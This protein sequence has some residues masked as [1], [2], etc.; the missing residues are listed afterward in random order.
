MGITLAYAVALV[1][2]AWLA[3]PSER[4]VFDVYSYHLPTIRT[5]AQQWPTPALSSYNVVSTPGYHLALSLVARTVSDSETLLRFVGGSFTLALAW[6][7]LR[8]TKDALLVVPLLLSLYVVSS[9]IYLLP[10]N[11]AWALVAIGLS[12]CLCDRVDRRFFI[13]SGVMLTTLV[14]VRQTHAWLG[15]PIA[16]ASFHGVEWRPLLRDRAPRL[17]LCV[18]PGICAIAFFFWLWGGLTPPPFQSTAPDSPENLGMIRYGNVTLVPVGFTCVVV[19]VYGLFFAPTLLGKTIRLRWVLLGA[20]LAGAFAIIVPSTVLNP[21]RAYAFWPL[22][23]KLPAVADRSIAFV[24][25]AIVGGALIGAFGSALPRRDR[26]ILGA[27]LLGFVLAH[28]PNPMVWQRYY[29]PLVLMLLAFACTRIDAPAGKRA[30]LLRDASL[31][32]LA[33][34]LFA[35]TAISL[36]LFT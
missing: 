27:A 1:V 23:N 14:L 2:I 13:L 21:F 18:L 33:G 16:A 17:L 20:L 4:I 36:R 5:F 30:R 35:V 24:L 28:L 31:L 3:T 19:G 10:E 25:L 26:V 11:A 32:A 15:L 22:L 34:G 7:M 6:V 29:E 12:L 9:A 8:V